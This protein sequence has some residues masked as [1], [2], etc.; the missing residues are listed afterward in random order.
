MTPFTPR[1]GALA[2]RLRALLDDV[3]ALPHREGEPVISALIA[4]LMSIRPESIRSLAEGFDPTEPV[5][6]ASPAEVQG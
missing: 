3:V 4:T 5:P 2:V 6:T 1:A